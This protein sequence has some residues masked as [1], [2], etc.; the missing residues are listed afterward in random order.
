MIS[1]YKNKNTGGGAQVSIRSNSP[2]LNRANANAG[3]LGQGICYVPPVPEVDPL[4]TIKSWRPC[5]HCGRLLKRLNGHCPDCGKQHGPG[6]DGST[7]DWRQVLNNRYALEGLIASGSFGEVYLATDLYTRSWV[8]VKITHQAPNPQDQ[9][10]IINCMKREQDVLQGIDHLNIVK[11][12]ARFKHNDRL[13]SVLDYIAGS[14]FEQI[15]A[16]GPLPPEH[17]VSLTLPLI[18]GIGH[19]VNKWGHTHNDLKPHNIIARGHTVT[20]LDFGSSTGLGEPVKV[21]AGTPGYA[22]PELCRNDPRPTEAS[23]LYSVGRVLA[24]LALDFEPNGAKHLFHLPTSDDDPNLLKPEYQS[25]YAFLRKATHYEAGPDC[26]A[27]QR[28]QTAKE[29]HAALEEVLRDIATI[30]GLS[31]THTPTG[32]TPQRG[33][34]AWFNSL[35]GRF[36]IP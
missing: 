5:Q 1:I 28:F 21:I 32:N 4:A 24:Y 14:T 23:D 33:L 29:M 11:F 35:V 7:L 19:L 15:R 16:N 18:R 12:H 13:V 17:A 22:A 27:Y 25:L 20:L 9:Q 31:P 30:K 36:K 10:D 8:A 6:S 26:G 2:S 34:R 3:T